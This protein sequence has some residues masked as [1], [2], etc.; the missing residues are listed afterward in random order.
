MK[1]TEG[2]LLQAI[3]YLGKSQILKILSP[4]AGLV[5]LLSKKRTAPPF[6]IGEWVYREGRSDLCFFQDFSLLDPLAALRDASQP[7]FAA[8]TI[9]KALLFTQWPGKEAAAVYALSCS[10]LKA[11]SHVPAPEAIASGFLLK[12]LALEGLLDPLDLSSSH[13]SPEEELLALELLSA[14]R[15]S[16]MGSTAVSEEL[17]EKISRFFEER[18][19]YD[20][21]G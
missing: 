12:L 9:A 11:L 5:T 8:G 4:E 18:I 21:R 6:C 3:S 13:F 7:L 10:A 19:N 1:K 15:Y 17:K 14:E 16:K 2:L 20:R